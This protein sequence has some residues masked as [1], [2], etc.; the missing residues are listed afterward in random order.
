MFPP[1]KFPFCTV[2]IQSLCALRYM[3]VLPRVPAVSKVKV[4][5]IGPLVWP[6]T[7]VLKST[8][9][10]SSF[11]SGSPSS[12]R[13]ATKTLPYRPL[14]WLRGCRCPTTIHRAA[15]RRNLIHFSSDLPADYNFGSEE[16]VAT[17][18]RR[19]ACD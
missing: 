14:Q 4:S 15:R 6:T 5:G 9:A 8:A 18:V 17:P 13:E 12:F 19:H 16:D 7:T 2:K 3:A 11:V 10:V 1:R